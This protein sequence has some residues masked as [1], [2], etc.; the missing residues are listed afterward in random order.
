MHKLIREPQ[1]NRKRNIIQLT[2]I[3]LIVT[4]VSTCF[5]CAPKNPATIAS[6]VAEDWA[7]SNVDG[8]SKSI[9]GLIANNNPLIEMAVSKTISQQINQRIAWEYSLPEKLAEERYKVV[10]TAYSVIEL[11]LLG[12]YR[13]SVNH[14]LEIDT[15][16]KKVIDAEMDAGSF[17][18]REL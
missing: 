13:V 15:R 3:F 4:V 16:Q 17:A 9:A 8:V 10:A 2:C 6:R 7:S 12:N 14:N 5:S 18:I 11:P 1:I